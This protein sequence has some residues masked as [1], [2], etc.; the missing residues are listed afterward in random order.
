MMNGIEHGSQGT[1]PK[2]P[3]IYANKDAR[4]GDL[5]SEYHTN[6]AAR[7]E[8]HIDSTDLGHE[9]LQI[10]DQMAPY[11]ADEPIEDKRIISTLLERTR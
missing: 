11:I 10:V 4:G 3:P 8:S 7:V 6:M 2:L 1:Q 5:S 9:N